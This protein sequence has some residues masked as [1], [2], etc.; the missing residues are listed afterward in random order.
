M[1]S[2]HANLAIVIVSFNR[3]DALLE[4]LSR[5]ADL[6]PTV[7]VVDNAS[8][9]DSVA[10]LRSHFPNVHVIANQTNAGVAAFNQGATAVDQ[11]AHA[12]AIPNT[13]DD[14]V[15]ILDDDARPDPAS[16]GAAINA[17]S[18]D[19]NLAGV[20]LLPIHPATNRP[21]WRATE[22]TNRF[23]MMGCANLVRRD[24]WRRAGGYCEAFFLYRN[25]T[26]LALSLLSLASQNTPTGL[27]FNPA[28][29]A[30]HDSPAATRKSDRWLHLA[31][32]NWI[33]MARRHGRG[34][35]RLLGI[36]L[37][38]LW[39]CKLA[40]LSLSRLTRVIRGVRDGVFHAAPP[41]APSIKPDGRA[42]R[43]LIRMQ[44]KR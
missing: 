17:L 30:H 26:D 44:M 27:A 12:R 29:F 28:W 38:T 6:A 11:L 3:R 37:G 5:V 35:W 13:P 43:D 1:P 4:T 42:Y 25:D 24:C 41:L 8:T 16:L 7:V 14:L 18:R 32:R 31:T 34:L 40:G 10:H 36:T 2:P 19:P 22:P 39:A 33:W 9:D 23:P 15:L 20:A 21:E